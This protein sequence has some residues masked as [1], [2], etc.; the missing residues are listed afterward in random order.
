M[1]FN[2]MPPRGGGMQPRPQ[3]VGLGPS[4]PPPQSMSGS[5][6]I[7]QGSQVGNMMQN[8]ANRGNRGPMPNLGPPRVGPNPFRPPTPPPPP[9]GMEPAPPNS[10]P[11]MMNGGNPP[12][13]NYAD[14]QPPQGGIP[15]GPQNPPMGG[16][17]MEYLQQLQNQPPRAIQPMQPGGPGGGGFW[18]MQNR[19]GGGGRIG[20]SWM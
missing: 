3:P 13:G 18:N 16:N 7:L 1:M 20:P 6:P 19:G 17:V 9:Q 4:N 2:Q 8:V 10:P 11:P 15:K 5:G 12:P 14:M